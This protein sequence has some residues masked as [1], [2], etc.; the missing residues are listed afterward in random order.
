MIP[1]QG[2]R[3]IALALCEFYKAGTNRQSLFRTAENSSEGAAGNVG[4]TVH[5]AP[6]FNPTAQ[7]AARQKTA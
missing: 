7:E 4:A 2:L 6:A 1:S 3:L 5:T